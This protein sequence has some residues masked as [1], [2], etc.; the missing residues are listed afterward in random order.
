MGFAVCQ[1]DKAEVDSSWPR[2]HS[3]GWHLSE[4]LRCSSWLPEA[5]A[6][7]N[8]EKRCNATRLQRNTFGPWP[9]FSPKRSVGWAGLT[10]RIDDTTLQW[11]LVCVSTR[12]KPELRK[13]SLSVPGVPVAFLRSGRISRH[14]YRFQC[15]V[16]LVRPFLGRTLRWGH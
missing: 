11:S 9:L 4:V 16:A 6:P 15:G 3:R 8:G 12:N 1:K 7:T 2:S 10:S 14:L 13:E 5:F